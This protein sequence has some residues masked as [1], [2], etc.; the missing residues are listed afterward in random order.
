MAA[1]QRM[2]RLKVDPCGV[3]SLILQVNS[4]LCLQCGKWMQGRCAGMKRVTPKFLRNFSCRKCEGNIGEAVYQKETLSDEVETVR[5]FTYLGDRVSA[6]GGCEAAVTARTR[7]GWVK[8]MECGELLYGR[9]FPLRLKGAVYKSYVTPAILYGSE[10]WC[11]K[12]S[13]MGILRR[14]ERSKDLMYM[15]GLKETIEQLAIASSVC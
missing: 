3:C 14:T 7:C 8:F 6:G 9:R 1:L 13:E 10:A 15:L 2:A 5:E 12:E 11:M 4:A